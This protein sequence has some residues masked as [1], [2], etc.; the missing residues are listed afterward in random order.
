MPY[1]PNRKSGHNRNA[2]CF[3]NLHPPAT[4]DSY[5]A[6]QER[7][8]AWAEYA[9]QV[10]A[11]TLHIRADLTFQKG[12]MLYMPSSGRRAATSFYQSINETIA[13]ETISNFLQRL[14]YAA[15]KRAA[16]RFGK[17]LRVI[18]SLEGGTAVLRQGSE[19]HKHLHAH[20][21]IELPAH[22]SFAEMS[23]AITINWNALEWSNVISKI[24]PIDSI[25]ASAAYNTKNTT[26]SLDLENTY[27]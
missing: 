9:S 15:Y 1:S 16:K 27:L 24:E 3:S 14:N 21:L 19:S 7:T 5:S 6:Q 25:F 10:G 12:R 22:L 11:N 4:P 26:D 23:A 2:F 18:T 20:L 13:Q 8:F 17:R